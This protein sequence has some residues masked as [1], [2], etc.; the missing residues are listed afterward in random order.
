MRLKAVR[1]I[2]RALCSIGGRLPV[3]LKFEMDC[4]YASLNCHSALSMWSIGG[5]TWRDAYLL[6]G[7]NNS[8]GY[9]V[10]LHLATSIDYWPN[11]TTTVSFGGVHMNTLWA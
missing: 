7:S 1:L 2:E 5:I 9:E 6:M 11:R 4:S 3:E 10:A 8:A